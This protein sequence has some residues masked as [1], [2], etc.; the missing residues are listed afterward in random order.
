[1][2]KYSSPQ[3]YLKINLKRLKLKVPMMCCKTIHLYLKLK[4]YLRVKLKKLRREN[5]SLIVQSSSLLKKYQKTKLIQ[6][7]KIK[8]NVLLLKKQH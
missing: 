1:M 5:K 4:R 3:A 2:K 6:I 8:I 7:I